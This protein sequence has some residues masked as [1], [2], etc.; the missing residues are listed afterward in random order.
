MAQPTFQETTR[1][2]SPGHRAFPQAFGRSGPLVEVRPDVACLPQPIVNVYFYGAPQ[3]P[4][5]SW[6][7]MDAG[8]P[9]FGDRI[10]RAAAERYG[11][12]SRPAAII[13]THGHF[14]HVGALPGLADRW[15]VPVYAHELEIPY[16]TG[17]SSYPP[18]DP[19]VGGGAMSFLSR[20]YPRGPIDLRTRVR[21]LP[22]DGTVPGMPGWRWLHT[23]GH[24]A[25]HVSLFRD[26]DR[27]LIAGDAF[28]T[29]KQESAV[30]ALITKP[31]EVHRPPA[32]YT[33]DWQAA[34]QS[35]EK[36][37]LLRPEV[38][39]TGHGLPMAGE[40]LRQG[41]DELVDDWGLVALPSY[42]RYVR[43]PAVI[44][45][46]GV[47]S[48]PPPVFDP[49]LAAVAGIGIAALAG[50]GLLRWWSRSNRGA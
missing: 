41:L 5:G 4:S 47:V 32:Y 49:Q 44:D 34:R 46:R 36:L 22:A 13:L 38:A 35:V 6:V 26:S 40:Q 14:D 7:L 30:A 15:G 42:G 2:T 50:F 21:T 45:E 25:G 37:A 43:R 24:T 9:L 39:A 16:L 27:T 19:A 1:E 33:P 11:P 29:T 20:F 10:V 23:P 48:V 31:Q 12:D 17:G 18:P 28:V 8:L 3:A